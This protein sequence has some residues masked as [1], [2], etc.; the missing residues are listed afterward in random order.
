MGAGP[1]WAGTG[2]IRSSKQGKGS[3]DE[4]QAASRVGQP[5][6]GRDAGGEWEKEKKVVLSVEV[7][8]K[9]PPG[10]GLK[11]RHFQSGPG[12]G[13]AETVPRKGT[14]H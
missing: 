13:R 12:R 8:I 1:W 9:S 5:P 2:P 11:G 14:R 10:G 4:S 7:L 3:V 6:L